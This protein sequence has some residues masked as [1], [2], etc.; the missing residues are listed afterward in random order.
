M[1]ELGDIV[2]IAPPLSI[3]PGADRDEPRA[4]VH[5]G[6]AGHKPLGD[7]TLRPNTVPRSLNILM[8][9]RV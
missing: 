8:N 3:F 4:V 2:F 6:D 1:M 7:I 9:R 5:I